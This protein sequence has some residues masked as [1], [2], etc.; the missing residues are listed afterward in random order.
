MEILVITGFS[1]AGKSKA[2]DIAEDL[3]YFSMDNLPPALLPKFVELSIGSK[4]VNRVAVVVDLRSGVFFDDFFSSLEELT[5]LQV[6]YKILFLDAEENV[7]VQRY[8]ELRRPHPLGDSIVAGYR[9]ERET[10]E[11]VRD[12]AHYVVNTSLLTPT[13][14]RD[15]LT[16]ILEDDV[17]Q[18]L[19][20]S[21]VSFGFKHGILKD[22]DLIFDVRFLPNPFY[23]PELKETNGNNPKTKEYVLKW[24]QTKEYLHRTVDLLE[25]L[26]PY[27]KDEGKKILVIGIGCTGGCH[28]SV[29]IANE[30]TRLLNEKGFLAKSRHRDL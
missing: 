2:L 29:A 12:Q 21:V 23:I 15:R 20:I 17:P 30:L 14:L 28:R 26:I 7:I 24:F 4:D 13:E 16:E 9:K 25:F 19:M 6:P 22:G 3:G 11:E 10:L 5:G 27:Y 1:G 8:K 18:D